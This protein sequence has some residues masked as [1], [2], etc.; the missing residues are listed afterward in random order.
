MNPE[1]IN[2]INSK[3]AME[4]LN[5]EY[6]GFLSIFTSLF[7]AYLIRIKEELDAK[8]IPEI[9]KKSKQR[10]L[11]FAIYLLTIIITILAFLTTGK[12]KYEGVV[13]ARRDSTWRSEVSN[14]GFSHAHKLDS[15]HK[16]YK[17]QSDTSQSLYR[18]LLA[19]AGKLGDTTRVISASTRGIRATTENIWGVIS[20]NNL[21]AEENKPVLEFVPSY[22]GWIKGDEQRPRGMIRKFKQL[23]FQIFNHGEVPIQNVTVR[24][25]GSLG[26]GINDHNEFSETS[27]PEAV[28][29]HFAKLGPNEGLRYHTGRF[30]G[31]F[32]EIR[33]ENIIRVDWGETSHRRWY[34][35]K[36]TSIFIT[37]SFNID[38]A[39][40]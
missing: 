10:K 40:L 17:I 32:G 2:K 5:E 21:S 3:L 37:E 4:W 24:L 33:L 38:R 31:A 27:P 29:K 6:L 39:L 28:T 22:I 11:R 14:L 16:E 13:A 35:L 26:M 30:N 15:L 23:E 25:T 20:R 12:V 18:Q 1:S 36:I 7:N 19:R 34:E 9:L 8:E